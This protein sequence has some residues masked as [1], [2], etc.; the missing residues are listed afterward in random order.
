MEIREDPWLS[1]IFGHGV[2]NVEVGD[3]VAE[4][5]PSRADSSDVLYGHA[6]RQAAAL[7]FSRVDTSRVGMVVQLSSAGFCVVEVSVQFDMANGSHSSWADPMGPLVSEILPDQHQRVLEIA[8]SCF[9]YSRF[10]LDP[11]VPDKIANR[12][13]H[14]WVLNYIRKKRGE[15]LLVASLDGR[16]VG[17]LAVLMSVSDGKRVGIIDL[18]GVSKAFQHQG[19]GKALVQSFFRQYQDQCDD[20][21]VGTQAAN[22]PS[23]RL[24]QSMGFSIVK[25]RYVLHMHVRDGIPRSNPDA[26]RG[27]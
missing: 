23:I 11:W 14:D 15:R 21:Q 27:I 7:Y 16:P 26:N 2:F 13:K 25:T 18:M 8:A 17:F 9:C 22:I 3:L 20:L 5:S 10:H 6:G 12:I 24:Y 4:H 1:S 19:V